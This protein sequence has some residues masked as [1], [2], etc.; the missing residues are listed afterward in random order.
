[1]KCLK[2][3]FISMACFVCSVSSAGE[4]ED[5]N[6]WFGQ[7]V[8]NPGAQVEEVDTSLFEQ[9]LPVLSSLNNDYQGGEDD[10]KA[11]FEQVLQSASLNGVD[12]AKVR[13]Q[14]AFAFLDQDQLCEPYSCVNDINFYQ[15]RHQ[16]EI[17]HIIQTGW[18]DNDYYRIYL[19]KAEAEQAFK[20][21]AW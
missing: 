21:M 18:G 16:G 2:L 5:F 1:M 12:K 13:S 3:A 17:L 4:C 11:R 7:A 14:L 10:N 9:C 6:V 20:I 8:A 15:V 19:F